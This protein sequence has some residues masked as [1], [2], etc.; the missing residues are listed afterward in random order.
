MIPLNVLMLRRELAAEKECRAIQLLPTRQVVK[1]PRTARLC[2]EPIDKRVHAILR[3]EFGGA[4]V[5]A[6]GNNRGL[7]AVF[8]KVNQA[9]FEILVAIQN[10]VV[11]VLKPVADLDICVF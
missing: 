2:P 10:N 9:L 7:V 1:G 4:R 6:C 8:Q 11:P 3:G 5:T